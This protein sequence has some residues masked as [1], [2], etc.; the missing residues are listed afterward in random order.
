MTFPLL[1]VLIVDDEAIVREGLKYVIDWSAMGYCICDDASSGAEA[2]EKIKKYNP[3]LV[4][5]DIH[6]PDMYGTELIGQVRKDGYTGAFI[7]ISGYSDFKY[8]QTALNHGASFYL[9]K[10][11]DEVAL[12]EAV[13][14]VRDNIVRGREKENSLSKYRSKAKSTI[15]SDLLLGMEVDFSLNY[16]EMGLYAP[17]YQVIIY[18]GY[19]PFYTAYNFAELLKVTNQGNNSFEHITINH[20]D[21]ILLKGSYALNRLST[22]L[23]YYASGTQSGSPLD[24]IFLT[25]G[26]IVSSLEDIRYSYED[27][28]LLM[29]RRF[30]C[31][32]NQHVLSETD[33]PIEDTYSFQVS[34]DQA[35][36]Y[37]NLLIDYIQTKN[38]RRIS[39]V[40]EEL[41]RDLSSCNADT[42]AIRHFLAD[43]F[44]LAKQAIMQKYSYADIPLAHNSAIIDLIENKYYLYEIL[45]YFSDQFDMMVRAIGTSSNEYI[46]DDILSYID[47]NYPQPLKLEAIASLFGYNS[48]Y[49]GKLF[50]QKMNQSFN[51]YLD[52]VRIMHSV[53][54]LDQT[55]LKVYE[56]ATKVGYSNVNYFHHKFKK[57]KGMSPAEYKKI[58]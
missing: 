50:T 31:A 21:I 51:S 29:K 47:H 38:K 36:H 24:S 4:L 6:M 16:A 14:T 19:H 48:S 57:L 34:A 11:I 13:K 20:Q 26:R 5:L 33:I 54:L 58:L 2:L 17:I 55:D 40:L 45:R 30:F 44:L 1:D 22:I 53:E 41:K 25:C 15:L 39:E 56:I 37:S 46:F 32:E 18:E 52:K 3:D 9:T 28:R 10:P 7:I 42:N 35:K 43:I 12:A 27:C 8:A 49:L 23:S